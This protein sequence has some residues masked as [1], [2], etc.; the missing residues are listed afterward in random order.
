[1]ILIYLNYRIWSIQLK[2]IYGHVLDTLA[3]DRNGKHIDLTK[4]FDIESFHFS[5]NRNHNLFD[6]Y[7]LL[8]FL[9]MF[10]LVWIFR[11]FLW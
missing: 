8:L 10:E 7:R 9:G 5:P 6:I 3:F 2:V 11:Q 1:M 4:T